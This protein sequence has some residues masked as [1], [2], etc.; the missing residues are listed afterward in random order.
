MTSTSESTRLSDSDMVI[1]GPSGLQRTSAATDV[2][3]EAMET[4]ESSDLAAD[5]DIGHIS[6]AG[7]RLFENK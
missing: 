1:A 2:E 3:A 4:I 7:D 6:S 5:G